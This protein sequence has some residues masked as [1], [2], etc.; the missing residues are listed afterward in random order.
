MTEKPVNLLRRIILKK[1]C[2]LLQINLWLIEAWSIVFRETEQCKTKI[3]KVINIYH[4]YTK[5]HKNLPLVSFDLEVLVTLVAM[6]LP[7]KPRSAFQNVILT[8]KLV[9]KDTNKILTTVQ[10]IIND[11]QVDTKPVNY[12]NNNH[13]N[14]R[15]V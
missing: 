3:D 15:N 12:N 7:P 4:D 6:I 11:Y 13:Y 2:N 8:K 14:H 5:F 9:F 1:F 10:K